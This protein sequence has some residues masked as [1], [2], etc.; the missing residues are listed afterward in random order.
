M[1]RTRILPA[2]VLCLFP[3]LAIT[4]RAAA[5]AT[6]NARAYR[7]Q[8]LAQFQ[9]GQREDAVE[10]FKRALSLRPDYADALND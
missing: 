1:R 4:P 7:Q 3:L 10:S 5:Q 2:V 9:S 6:D 8:G